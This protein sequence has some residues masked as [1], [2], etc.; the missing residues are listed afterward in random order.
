MDNLIASETGITIAGFKRLKGLSIKH[1]NIENN[2]LVDDACLQ[3]IVRQWP[4]MK[5]LYLNECKITKKGLAALAALKRLDNLSLQGLNLTD[6]SFAP[7]SRLKSLTSLDISFNDKLTD[8]SMEYVLKLPKLKTLHMHLL[9]SVSTAAIERLKARKI[10]Y[11]CE[12]RKKDKVIDMA[13]I[14]DLKSCP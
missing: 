7:I 3:T 6:D 10:S 5:T 13:D 1:L 11:Q 14:L 9:T 12:D 8:R 2:K 4:E